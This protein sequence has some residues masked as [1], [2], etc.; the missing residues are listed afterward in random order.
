MSAEGRVTER[1]QATVSG[2]VRRGLLIFYGIDPAE[3]LNAGNRPWRERSDDGARKEAAGEAADRPNMAAVLRESVNSLTSSALD[4]RRGAVDYS[5]LRDSQAYADH[6]E[7]AGRLAAFDPG[8]L[9]SRAE[10]TAFWI[11]LYNA[12][13]IDAVIAYGIE[14]SVRE[15]SGFFWRAAYRI[16]GERYSANDIE[17][18]ILRANRGHPAIPGPHLGPGDPRRA[19]V[20]EPVDPRIHFALNCASRSCPPISVYDAALLDQ[21][22]D[23]AAR[24][25]V[26]NGGVRVDPERG[27]VSLSRIFFWYGGDF[28]GARGALEFILP[29][30]DDGPARTFLTGSRNGLKVNYQP[31]DWSLNA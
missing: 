31:Y 11:N 18:G 23:L 27:R 12:L 25:F 13:L 20:I 5:R 28:G 1:I 26:N 29:Y 30:L 9:S 17:H 2:A 10:R 19:H 8:E 4:R 7:C 16:G 24:S 14:K 21:Q 6:Q 3:V 15:V 22:L